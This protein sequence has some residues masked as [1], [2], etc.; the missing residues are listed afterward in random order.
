MTPEERLAGIQARH[1]D[2][3]NAESLRRAR[4]E[5]VAKDLPDLVAFTEAVLALHSP[6]EWGGCPAC[7]LRADQKAYDIDDC[8]VHQLAVKHLGGGR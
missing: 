7:H 5:L 6:D 1:D 3:A 8:P 4:F 2:L